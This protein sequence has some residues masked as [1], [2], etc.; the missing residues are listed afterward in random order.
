MTQS[1]LPRVATKDGGGGVGGDTLDF[2]ERA[3]DGIS[4]T[5][6]GVEQQTELSDET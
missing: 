2:Y 3:V 5:R 1:A 4:G 6:G